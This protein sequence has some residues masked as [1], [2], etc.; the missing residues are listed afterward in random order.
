[1]YTYLIFSFMSRY[2]LP[3]SNAYGESREFITVINLLILYIITRHSV[4]KKIN[5]NNYSYNTST[6]Y[7]NNNYNKQR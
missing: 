2:L 7:D 6:Y 3:V 1:M 4:D 5:N